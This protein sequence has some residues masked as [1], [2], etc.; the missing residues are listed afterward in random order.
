M[1]ERHL[2]APEGGVA[3]AGDLQ[4]EARALLIDQGQEEVAQ[5]LGLAPHLAEIDAVEGVEGGVEGGE[6][7]NRRGAALE[8][9]DSRRRPIVGLEGERGAVPEPAGERRARRL[10]Q[11]A[12][13]VDEGRRAGAAVQELV[14]AA[15]RQV[16]TAAAE[17]DLE[18]AGAVRQVPERQGAVVV[19]GAGDP[20]HVAQLAALEID[21][22]ETDHRYLTVDR[23]R[24]IVH[25]HPP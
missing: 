21:L 18:G 23:G 19:G 7:E 2:A 20:R 24:E 22:A 14:A 1:A 17:V 11:G 9:V 4:A 13:N 8:A 16:G 3:R 5:G 6:A 10:L 12:G 25:R 15:H